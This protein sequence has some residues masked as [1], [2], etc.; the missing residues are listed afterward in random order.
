[1][2]AEDE[3]TELKREYSDTFLKT[4]VAFSN[5]AG[6]RILIGIDDLGH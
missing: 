1:M 5:G 6:G 4:A 2:V 3:R